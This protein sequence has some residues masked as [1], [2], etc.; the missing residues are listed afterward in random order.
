MKLKL[1]FWTLSKLINGHE[2]DVVVES[3]I[4]GRRLF[5]ILSAESPEIF[6]EYKEHELI[7]I[8][9][10]NGKFEQLKLEDIISEDST[11][12]FISSLEGG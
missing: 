7:F 1:K 3:N 5:E 10:S 4:T 9:R 8:E 11:I 2:M 12:V 6:K